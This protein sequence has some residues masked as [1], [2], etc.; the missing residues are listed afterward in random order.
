MS[1]DAVVYTDVPVMIPGPDAA[2][3][4]GESAEIVPRDFVQLPPNLAEN[5]E[6]V[7]KFLSVAQVFGQ[8]FRD[9]PE[10][11]TLR[12]NMKSADAMYRASKRKNRTT[13]S[14]QV[15]DTLSNV[16]STSFYDSVRVTTAGQKA[17]I[18]SGDELPARYEAPKVATDAENSERERVASHQNLMLHY[19]WNLCD[20]EQR[21]KTSLLFNNKYGQEMLC[22]EWEYATQ[23]KVE[24]VPGYYTKGGEPV[25]YDPE[26]PVVEMYDRSGKQLSAVIDGKTGRPSHFVFIEKTKVVRDYP[27]LYRTDLKDA[28]FDM[29]I[30]NMQDQ[31]CVFF[32][33]STGIGALYQMQ[34]DGL[35]ANVAR[36]G[37]GQLAQ[38]T[39]THD[40]M[41]RSDRHDNADEAHSPTETGNLRTF[42][43]W[44]RA[45]IDDEATSKKS[46]TTRGKWD[47]A[48]NLPV[49]YKAVFVGLY[50]EAA[51]DTSTKVKTAGDRPGGPVCIELRKNPYHDGELPCHLIHSHEDDKGAAHLG[52]AQLL[53]CYYEEETTATNQLFDNRNLGVNRPWIA[54]QNNVLTR[55]MKFRHGNQVFHVKAGSGKTALTQLDVTDMTGTI[56][57]QLEYIQRRLNKTAG[58]DKAISGEYAGSRT[59]G[60]EVLQVAQQAMKPALEDA[61][62]I[63]GQTFPWL[64]RIFESRIRQFADPNKQVAITKENVVEAVT[65]GDLYGETAVRVVSIG[66][67]EADMQLRQTLNNFLAAAYDK[68]APNMT[69]DD[70]VRFWRTVF[71]MMKIPDYGLYF[72]GRK[73]REAENQAY[74]ENMLA[75][76]DPAAALQDLPMQDENHEVHE[77]SHRE[78]R[79]N[80]ES[81]TPPDQQ[82]PMTV[83]I[84]RGWEMLH[85][86]FAQRESA[87]QPVPQQALGGPQANAPQNQA[88]VVPGM[89]GE[90]SGDA[91]AG[92]LAGGN[93]GP[94]VT[95]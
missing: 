16:S 90:A 62:Y 92:A 9:Q 12:D 7:A 19:Y 83:Q 87:A 10:R 91:M 1:D 43:V 70:V 75:V 51:A 74:T 21:L 26:T 11:I 95:A 24:R 47:S 80:Y 55:N 13:S 76:N 78:F 50:E 49:W 30:D 17:V 79:E 34:R 60:T 52:Y 45:P 42:T 63:A 23:S 69:K 35:C 37:L 61:E 86:R 66:Q 41:E 6:L 89:G 27:L 65:P 81:F 20:W 53:E 2:P 71:R 57:P 58:T 44:M 59:T 14:D 25:E 77:R 82:N 48:N 84:L 88:D 28:W 68:A 56:L 93:G 67:F 29:Q 85:K 4:V 22:M 8:K 73:T 15:Q 18:F 64:L 5:H 72:G 46:A 33:G 36:I 40:T 32:F 94:Q 54:E 31:N 3:D 38:S 39:D